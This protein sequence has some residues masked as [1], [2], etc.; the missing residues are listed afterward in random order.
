[1]STDYSAQIISE[2]NRISNKLWEISTALFND[3]EIAFNEYNASKILVD[4]LESLG[5]KSEKGISGLETAFKATYG[6]RTSPTIAILAEYDALVGLGHACGHNLIASAAVGAAAGLAAVGAKLA[7]RIEIIGTPAEEGGGGKIILAKAG[8]FD[9]VDAAM[10][11]HPASKNMVLRRS[12]ADSGVK[13]EFFGKASHAAAA[14]EEGI[15]ALDAMILTFNNINAF[16]QTMGLKD[17]IAGIITHGGEMANIVPAYTAAEFSIRA[18]STVRRD[19][20]VE[21]VIS[22]AQAGAQAVGC[23]LK[24]TINPG[25]REII[26]NK[27][28]AG[29]FTA[30]LE[31]L[32]RQVIVPD[33][34]ERM[35]STD[36]GDISH[37]VPAIHP[38]LAIAPEKVAGHTIEFREYC[39]SEAGKAAMLDAA[40]AMALTAFDLLENPNYLV[41]ARKELH[42]VQSQE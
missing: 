3:P 8:I 27:V 12:L 13:I 14:P 15:N 25:Y 19:A 21:K 28:M 2:I 5:Y 37:L 23:E 38:Y 42:G 17:R 4:F 1:M 39:K 26:P 6:N 36:M 30:N 9:D 31:R 35:G 41:E 18:L 40:K 22:C 11:F 24:Y 20:L 16:R 34:N 33:V 29:L 32:G 10:M 7:G